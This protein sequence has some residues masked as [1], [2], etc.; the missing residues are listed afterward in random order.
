MMHSFVDWIGYWALKVLACAFNRLPL[1]CALHIGKL[2]GYASYYCHKRGRVAYVNLKAAFGDR[3]TPQQL[4][5]IARTSF[6]NLSQNLVEMLRF[7]ALDKSYLDTYVKIDGLEKI[8]AALHKGKGLIFLTAHFG[9]WELLG[10]AS[11]L[12]GFPLKVLARQQKHSRMN[13]LLNEFRSTHG[14]EVIGK[15]MALREIMQALKKNEIV[16][17]LSDQSGGPD[18]IYVD[19][20]G[21]K[22]SS[23]PGVI[24]IAQRTGCVVL[25]TFMVRKEKGYHHIFI[26]AALD[27]PMTGN[28]HQD[29]QSGLKNYLNLLEEFISQHPD[30]WL[31]MHKRWKHTLDRH[32]AIIT[33]NKA[34]HVSQSEGVFNMIQTLAQEKKLSITKKI[35][36]VEF[37][38]SFHRFLLSSVTLLMMPFIQGR[39]ALLQYF[40]TPKSYASLK[41]IYADIVISCGSQTLP[42]NL[43]LAK[44]NG[45]K[46]IVI[47]KPP[48]PFSACSYDLMIVPFHD[49]LS[50]ERKNVVQLT[51]ALSSVT[52][53]LLMSEGEKLKKELKLMG[54]PVIS[55]FI[56]G[57]S[58]RYHFNA[59]W[60]KNTID[61]LVKVCNEQK[62]ELLITTSRRTRADIIDIL[63]KSLAQA[64][65]CKLLIVATE[66]NRE[67]IVPA[68]MAVAQ[69]IMVTEDSVSMISE[70]I[71]SER[72]V[73]VLKMAE[74]GIAQKFV[75]FQDNLVAQKIITMSDYRTVS[76]DVERLIVSTVVPTVSIEERQRLEKKLRSLL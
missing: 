55:L 7:P 62:A 25:P 49:R 32:I 56:G 48:F 28:E 68:M 5:K 11:T 51:T 23:P 47:M 20:F 63:K 69:L 39:L 75:R 34:G 35:V 3:Y 24:S 14:N 17:I 15:G 67:H 8:T 59:E 1:L 74:T 21:R 72:N 58:K 16:G 36:E 10:V 45:A 53:E 76:T 61:V 42:L 38:S 57:E 40:L 30:Q 64:P 52:P 66:K 4:K 19:F 37:K 12:T 41:D 46:K 71:H 43:L 18:G 26:N 13:D 65:C 29:L 2:F 33:D 22:T 73:I 27:I 9:N 31:W 60:F 70:G 54:R 6:A 44:E 50:D